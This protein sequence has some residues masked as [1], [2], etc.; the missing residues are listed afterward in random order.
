MNADERREERA[1][2][3]ECIPL[4]DG[5][6]SDHAASKAFLRVDLLAFRFK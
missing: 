4:P 3:I 6:G 1:S 2:L 5:R